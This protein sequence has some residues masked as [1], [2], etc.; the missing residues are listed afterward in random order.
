MGTAV[1]TSTAKVTAKATTSAIVMAAA[2]GDDSEG[3]WQ[4]WAM[5]IVA[6]INNGNNNSDDSCI[7]SGD[8]NEQ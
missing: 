4:R 3:Q 8:S 2:M 5:K 6:A 1:A 7:N